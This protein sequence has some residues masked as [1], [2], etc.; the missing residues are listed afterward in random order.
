VANLP[1]ICKSLGFNGNTVE[2]CS[3]SDVWHAVYIWHSSG[4]KIINNTVAAL[5]TSH[6]AAIS[7]YDGYNNTQI[8]LGNLS[9]NNLVANNSLTNKG[10]ALGAWDRQPGPA[11]QVQ[12]SA[13]MQR[14]RSA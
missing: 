5:T 13:A 4:N 9:T 14:P 3:F 2:K 8:N 12:K 1:G 11:T 10:I 6:C 7:S